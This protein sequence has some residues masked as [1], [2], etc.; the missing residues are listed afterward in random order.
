MLPE[1]LAGD[2]APQSIQEEY[3]SA[4][5]VMTLEETTDLLTRRYLMLRDTIN[6]RGEVL[7]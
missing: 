2:D 5:D 3:S 7:R 4:R 6:S 1:V